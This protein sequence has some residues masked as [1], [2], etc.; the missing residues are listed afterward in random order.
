MRE[1]PLF[2]LDA[3][4]DAPF[5]G[6]PAAVCPLEAWLDDALMQ[7]IALENNLSE[8][9]FLVREPEGWRIR[10]FTPTMEIDLC[11]HATLASGW[12]VMNRLEPG[13]SEVSFASRSGPLG[14]RKDGERYELDF[15]ARP[16]LPTEAPAGLAEALG[17]QPR[18][19]LHSEYWLAVFEDEAA[20]RAL[21]PDMAKLERACPGVICSARGDEVDFVSRFFG[22]GYG[23]PEDP[24]TG[25][26]HC[27][28]TPYWAALLGKDELVALQLSRRV[29]SFVC[30]HRGERTRICGQVHLVIEGRLYL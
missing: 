1:L 12:V 23:V 5:A 25:S 6:N 11:G 20:V 18:E 14:V 26:A 4:A 8:T 10:W 2:Q 3:F 24:A 22:P 9:A 7:S 30:Q 19:V 29:G 27:V 16:P 17:A 21:A 13:A 28:L 15:P